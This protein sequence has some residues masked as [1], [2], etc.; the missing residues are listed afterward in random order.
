[1]M[2]GA[3]SGG[4]PLSVSSS[5]T[6]SPRPGDRGFESRP[7]SGESTANPVGLAQVEWPVRRRRSLWQAQRCGWRRASSL[8]ELRKPVVGDV[9]PPRDPGVA[10]VGN[11]PEDPVEGA[12]AAGSPDHPQ[13]KADRHHL[14]HVRPLAMQPVEG[15]DHIG[16]E[17]GGAAEPVG[18]RPSTSVLLSPGRRLGRH[19]VPGHPGHSAWLAEL[20][21]RANRPSG[22]RRGIYRAGF[23]LIRARP[24]R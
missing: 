9:G 11:M 15:I 2:R 1:M 16:G 12:D 8:R 20:C 5:A 3:S 18:I 14:R 10:P 22:S 4:L 23:F 6:T 17:I 21:D 19:T 13:V 24:A 7:S